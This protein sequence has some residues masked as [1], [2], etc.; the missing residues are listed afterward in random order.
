MDAFLDRFERHF[1][2]FALMCLIAVGSLGITMGKTS[3][4]EYQARVVAEA[5]AEVVAAEARAER[6]MVILKRMAR[7]RLMSRRGYMDARVRLMSRR[8]YMDDGYIDIRGRLLSRR[9]IDGELITL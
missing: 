4:D 3:Y 2:V 8:G 6:E 5:A 1:E 9:G 7:V